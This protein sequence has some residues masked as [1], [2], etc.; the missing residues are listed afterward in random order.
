MERRQG[1]YSERDDESQGMQLCIVIK[2]CRQAEAKH[3]EKVKG[4]R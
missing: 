1:I 4:K 2:S 3:Q